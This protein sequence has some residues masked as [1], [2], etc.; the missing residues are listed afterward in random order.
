MEKLI[1][2]DSGGCRMEFFM[3][4]LVLHGSEQLTAFNHLQAFIQGTRINGERLLSVS[5]AGKGE[6]SAADVLHANKLCLE[7]GRHPPES[8]L[9]WV[10]SGS[11]E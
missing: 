10:R 9:I 2:G 5:H 4:V 3:V 8:I 7:C 6:S 11:V 1:A